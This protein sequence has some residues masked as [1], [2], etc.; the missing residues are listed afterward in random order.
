MPSHDRYEIV[1][2]GAG[3]L[4]LATAYH[5]AQRRPGRSVLVVDALAGPGEG[6]MGASNSMVRD[7]FSSPDNRALA[8]ASIRFYEHV[9]ESEAGCRADAPSR[10]G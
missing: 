10:S 2:V 6:S 4:G 1:I 7:V 3:P 8:G 9:M 5:L